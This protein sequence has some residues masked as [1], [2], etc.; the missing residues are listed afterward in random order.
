MLF[1]SFLQSMECPTI[2]INATV[3]EERSVKDFEKEIEEYRVEI[4]L[5]EQAVV[6]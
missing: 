2:Y 1:F 5:S 4:I 6:M 3:N